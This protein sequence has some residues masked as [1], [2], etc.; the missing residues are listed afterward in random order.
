MLYNCCSADLTTAEPLMS[1]ITL[2]SIVGFPLDL[3]RDIV[4]H[5]VGDVRDF[6]L[7]VLK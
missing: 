6:Y 4:T 1:L 5:Y 7:Y 3:I 2:G